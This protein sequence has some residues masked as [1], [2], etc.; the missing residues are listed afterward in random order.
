MGASA[1]SAPRAGGAITSNTPNIALKPQNLVVF[2]QERSTRVVALGTTQSCDTRAAVT[3]Q[4]P[5]CLDSH[6]PSGLGMGMVGTEMTGWVFTMGC[7]DL[8]MGSSPQGAEHPNNRGR[9]PVALRCAL[10][11]FRKHPCPLHGAV[12]PHQDMGPS[13]VLDSA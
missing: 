10:R 4:C 8:G 1:V 6:P 11:P 13:R 5:P 2:L 3:P 9:K 12:T 7:S